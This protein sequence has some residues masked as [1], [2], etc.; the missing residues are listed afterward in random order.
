MM[1]SLYFMFFFFDF[2]MYLYNI[3]NVT[4]NKKNINILDFSS[5]K[6]NVKTLFL[7]S[8]VENVVFNY[9][10]VVA[11]VI[12]CLYQHVYTRWELK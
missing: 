3:H 4:S 5:T 2:Y 8:S 6:L 9:G 1:G 7:R 12:L 10:F 11:R